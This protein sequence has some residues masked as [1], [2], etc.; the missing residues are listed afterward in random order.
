M[1]R[2][3]TFKSSTDPAFTEKP[4]DV[5]GLYLHPPDKAAVLC[6]DEKSQIQALDRTQPGL[7]MKPGRRGTMTHDYKRNG[8]TTFV[9]RVERAD[10]QGHRPMPREAQSSAA[11]RNWSRRRSRTT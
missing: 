7:P 3:K 8:I 4:T 10:R 11:C 1:R 6:V 5:V 2:V 9:R